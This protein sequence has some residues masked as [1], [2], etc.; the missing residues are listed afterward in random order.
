ML[1]SCLINLTFLSTR[2]F[3]LGLDSHTS[4]VKTRALNNLAKVMHVTGDVEK[5]WRSPFELRALNGE[6]S[7]RRKSYRAVKSGLMAS[8]RPR[9][10]PKSAKTGQ[11]FV[12][13]TDRFKCT[14]L[15]RRRIDSKHLTVKNVATER[16]HLALLRV[17]TE[18]QLISFKMIPR[19]I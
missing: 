12:I 4:R 8:A 19:N 1:S 14:Q 11:R 18:D 7:R 16:Q 9:I 2:L 3:C 13:T 10:S 6:R 5:K 15:H 17:S